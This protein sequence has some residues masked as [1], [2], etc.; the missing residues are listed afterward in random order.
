MRRERAG[1][2]PI[3]DAGRQVGILTR[4]GVLDAFDA[5]SPG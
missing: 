4:S 5:A 1:A 3:V 2:I